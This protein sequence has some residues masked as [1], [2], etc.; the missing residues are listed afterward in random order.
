MCPRIAERDP[1]D[2]LYNPTQLANALQDL[3]EA[4]GP[5]GVPICDP[6]VL[7]DGC[8]SASDVLASQQLGVALE[9]GCHH[10]RGP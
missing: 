10:H 6:S 5:D 9:A 1:E 4:V 8:R 2:F 3:I 7:V